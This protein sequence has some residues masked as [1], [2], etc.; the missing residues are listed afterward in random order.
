MLCGYESERYSAHGTRR[1]VCMLL[2]IFEAVLQEFLGLRSIDKWKM[3]RQ[4]WGRLSPSACGWQ[5]QVIALQRDP[6]VL[7]RAFR[8]R[9][10]VPS[11]R[12]LE[13]PTSRSP[14]CR[15]N[16]RQVLRSVEIPRSLIAEAI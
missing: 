1:A 10:L 4:H 13:Q 16:G 11:R 14:L 8:Y 7:Y 12:L 6:G 2:Q 3:M 9:Q 15:Q 5:S